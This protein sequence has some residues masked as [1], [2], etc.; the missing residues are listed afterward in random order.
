MPLWE[1]NSRS[2]P[3]MSDRLE[4]RDA[5]SK[6]HLLRKLHS[7]LCHLHADVGPSPTLGESNAGAWAG[8]QVEALQFD[9]HVVMLQLMTKVVE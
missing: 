2:T 4:F 1:A 9:Q 6:N 3:E 8:H 7:H 5:Y